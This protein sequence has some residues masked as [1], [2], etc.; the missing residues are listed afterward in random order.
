VCCQKI[1]VREIAIKEGSVTVAK[2][3]LH[4][5]WQDFDKDIV[6]LA[7]QIW[8]SRWQPDYIVGITRGGLPLAVSLS[9]Y[10]KIPM[11][12]LGVSLR[13]GGD[14]ESNLWM[15][16]DAFGVVPADQQTLI[17]SRWDVQ[18]R[19]NILIVDDINDTGA[20]FNWIVNDWQASCYP[21]EQQVWDV[22][23]GNSVR[24]ATLWDNPT[25]LSKYRMNYT[26]HEKDVE[27]DPWI[28]FPW[29]QPFVK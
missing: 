3:K 24:F 28:V 26:V 11:H 23:W 4:Y 8:L 10:M 17:K 21:Q 12:A 16:E 15:A 27:T 20:T 6:E 29:E 22:V 25:S 5:S 14:A 7:R 9:N 18:F 13:D 2:N 19:K 1:L